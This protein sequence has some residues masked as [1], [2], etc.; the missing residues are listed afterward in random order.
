MQV[1]MR[2]LGFAVKKAEVKGL[3]AEYRKDDGVGLELQEFMEI[4]EW[5]IG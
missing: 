2:A 3:M 4:S 5:H 1:A